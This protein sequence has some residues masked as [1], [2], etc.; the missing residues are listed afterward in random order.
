[1]GI[2]RVRRRWA[3]AATT[4]VGAGPRAA[5]LCCAFS[6]M[7]AR[8]WPARKTSAPSAANSVATAPPIEPPAP[9]TTARLPCRSCPVLTLTSVDFRVSPDL[10]PLVMRCLG[11]VL[12][13]WYDDQGE[14]RTV[15]RHERGALL[16][17]VWVEILSVHAKVAVRQMRAVK[18]HVRWKDADAAAGALKILCRQHVD[19]ARMLWRLEH[20]LG[21]GVGDKGLNLIAGFPL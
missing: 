11:V 10:L 4:P 8:V 14:R 9:K 7:S 17:P 15:T 5:P 21:G 12:T 6:S 16:I 20:A 3:G 13:H 2:T 19:D 18:H 1:P